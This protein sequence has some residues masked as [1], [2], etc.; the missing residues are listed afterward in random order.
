MEFSHV[1]QALSWNCSSSAKTRAMW[2]L[3][4]S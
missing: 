2:F 3:C 1:A 4:Y